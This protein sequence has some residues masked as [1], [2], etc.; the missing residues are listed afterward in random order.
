MLLT[1]YQTGI[2]EYLREIPYIRQPHLLWLMERKHGTNA[3]QLERDLRQ[4][5]YLG[6]IARYCDDG[7][8]VSLPG[9]KRDYALLR[10][11]DVMAEICG[12]SLPVPLLGEPPCK[13]SF[14]LRDNRGY[15]DF[16]V[17]PV[18]DGEEQSVLETLQARYAGFRCT[19]LFLI[20]DEQQIP[21]LWTEKPAYY[22]ISDDKGGNLFLKKQ[23]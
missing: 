7:G 14:Y 20:V 6:C 23:K 1:V 8:F 5:R 19:Y 9:R 13:L 16:K 22:V 3:E 4:L 12:N 17:I 2:L 21:R 10:A 18:P 15:L 11:T